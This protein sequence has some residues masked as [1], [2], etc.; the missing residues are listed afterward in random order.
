MMPPNAMITP[1][2]WFGRTTVG[3]NRVR[4]VVQ[5]EDRALG[6]ASHTAKEQLTI[7]LHELRTARDVRVEALGPAIVQGKHIVLRCL[8]QP[9]ALQLAQ[10][11]GLLLRE[12]V[13][14]RPI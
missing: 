1:S 14:L 2:A 6:Q 11:L 4:L 10:L 7:A 13:G 9:K 8:D 12:I 5:V 3:R